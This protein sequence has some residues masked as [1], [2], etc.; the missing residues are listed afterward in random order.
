MDRQTKYEQRKFRSDGMKRGQSASTIKTKRAS[1]RSGKQ[2][3]DKETENDILDEEWCISKEVVYDDRIQ[4]CSECGRRL[5]PME[6]SGMQIQWQLPPHKKKGYKI[7]RKK[8][9]NKRGK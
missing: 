4:R 5:K 1:K 6:P 7:K 9:H 3:L 8:G 2:Y